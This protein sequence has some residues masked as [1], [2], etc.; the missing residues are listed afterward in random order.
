MDKPAQRVSAET[1][2]MQA[3]D[4]ETFLAEGDIDRLRDLFNRRIQYARYAA[5]DAL[6]QH[7]SKEK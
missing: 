3:W 4:V 2:S 7:R 5:I 6:D 1:L